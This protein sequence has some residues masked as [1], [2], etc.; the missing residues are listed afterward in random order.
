[1]EE[2]PDADSLEGSP[3]VAKSSRLSSASWGMGGGSL[4]RQHS[5]LSVRTASPTRN[6]K[7]SPSKN[8]LQPIR[9]EYERLRNS[10]KLT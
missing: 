10:M 6:L 9:E 1:M 8:D 2:D 7:H 3:R 4:S 5:P